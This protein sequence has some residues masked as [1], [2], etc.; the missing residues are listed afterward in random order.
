M[1][2]GRFATLILIVI[3][4]IGGVGYYGW[5]QQQALSARI[6]TVQAKAENAET[7]AGQAQAAAREA[8]AAAEEARAAKAAGKETVLEADAGAAAA[9]PRSWPAEGRRFGRGCCRT[10]RALRGW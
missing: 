3:I 2:S 5:T 10:G 9:A 7:S 1:E 4:L 8:K 6:D